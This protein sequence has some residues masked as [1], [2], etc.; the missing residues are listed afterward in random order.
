VRTA[1]LAVLA[2]LVALS[3]GCGGSGDDE[4]YTDATR[5]AFV[6][7]CSSEAALTAGVEKA[8][9]Q[10]QGMC[11]CTYDELKQRMSYEEFKQVDGGYKLSPEAEEKI[12][13]ALVACRP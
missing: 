12:E 5:T 11:G 2:V 10:M 13:S 8:S 1:P 3:A 6:S 4:D 9:Q 7:S